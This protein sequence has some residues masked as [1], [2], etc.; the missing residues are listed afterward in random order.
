MLIMETKSNDVLEQ[1]MQAEAAIVSG[2]DYDTGVRTIKE[3][4]CRQY[5]KRSVLRLMLLLRQV[6]IVL[7]ETCPAAALAVSNCFV[8]FI[9]PSPHSS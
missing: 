2:Q 4:L 7:R 3:L 8:L 9:V 5:D 6:A 1:V